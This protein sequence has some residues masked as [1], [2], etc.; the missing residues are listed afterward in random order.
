MGPSSADVARRFD[1]V[2]VGAGHNGLVGAAVLARAGLSVLVVEAKASIGGACRTE[3]PFARCPGVG[4]STGAYLLGPTP[5]EVLEA[6]GL[7]GRIKILPR[8]PHGY[9]LNE[10]GMPVALGVAGGDAHLSPHD[11]AAMLALD[12]AVCA[13]RDDTG[14]LWL[15]T[16]IDVRSSVL[17]VREDVVPGA[18]G[19]TVRDLY[20]GLMLGEEGRGG[21]VA[22]L[23]DRFRFE[24]PMLRAVIATDGLV[25][26]AGG[27]HDAGTGA[28]FLA[29]NML[30]LAPGD[31]PWEAAPLGAWQLVEGGM[32]AVTG[33]LRAVVEEH[34]GEVRTGC[35]ARRVVSREGAAAGVELG[36]GTF[37]AAPRV[38]VAVDPR[39]AA[40]LMAA[41]GAGPARL[42]PAESGAARDMRG[43]SLKVNMALRSLPRV[44]GVERLPESL[45]H[46]QPLNGTVH[47]LPE[48]DVEERLES[49]RRAA[50]EEER[51]PDPDD[52]MIDV[53]THSAVDRSLCDGEGRHAMSLFVQWVPWDM[54]QGRA[55]EFAQRLIRGPVAR[56]MPELP[57]LVE[58]MMV[59]GPRQIEERFGIRGGHIHHVDNGYAMER[60]RPTGPGVKG[61]ALAGAG[62]HPAGSVIGCSGLLA[63]RA[64]LG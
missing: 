24:S 55:D 61:V 34:G 18:G 19:A 59:L 37:V 38:L 63:A 57:G 56:V 16:A 3:R 10:R 51:T 35:G 46:V 26:S 1:A 45:R 40:A 14:P 11:R 5:P 12:G 31:G 64:L 33:A 29:H 2:V 36:D 6:A 54:D 22:G 4:C 17:R 41:D 42:H 47:V 13:M 15:D 23:V 60:R 50:V 53:Y 44:A 48:G 52:C 62:W 28:N 20:R 8:R 30:R 21:S 39:A 25:G 58:D 32:G 49:A 7:R 43:T 9:F 27:M